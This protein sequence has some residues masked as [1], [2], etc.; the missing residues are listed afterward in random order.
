MS[1]TPG[2]RNLD[3]DGLVKVLDSGLAKLSVIGASADDGHVTR[4]LV[5]RP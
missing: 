4:T 1:L 5:K 2:S 3:F